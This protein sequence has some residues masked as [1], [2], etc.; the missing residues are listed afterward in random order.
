MKPVTLNQSQG[1]EDELAQLLDHVD[2]LA[3]HLAQIDIITSERTGNKA[4]VRFY[5][6]KAEPL[7]TH[8]RKATQR[9]ASDAHAIHRMLVHLAGPSPKS[10]ADGADFDVGGEG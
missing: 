4:M 6:A 8:M 1:E 5:N 10:Q 2:V 3:D 9:M 7:I